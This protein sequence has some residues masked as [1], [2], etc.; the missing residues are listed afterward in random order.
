MDMSSIV[1]SRKIKG[2]KYL[3]ISKLMGKDNDRGQRL[4]VKEPKKKRED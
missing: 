1:R 3:K 2:K 4:V